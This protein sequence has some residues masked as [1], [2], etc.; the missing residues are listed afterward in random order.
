MDEPEAYYTEWSKSERERQILYINAYIGNLE[1]WHQWSYMQG[2]KGDS[3]VKNRL[4]DCG[5]RRQWYDLREQYW[6]MYI[7]MYKID[8]QGEFKYEAGNPK[9]VLWDKPEE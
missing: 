4:L 2:S 5:R 3:D 6:N 1:K 9:L 8:D 7:T